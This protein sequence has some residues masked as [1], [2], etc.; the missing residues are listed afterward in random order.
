MLIK[1]LILLSSDI[2]IEYSN[3]SFGLTL[4]LVPVDSVAFAIRNSVN[5][6]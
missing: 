6:S 4:C 1:C 3:V 2:A 5:F